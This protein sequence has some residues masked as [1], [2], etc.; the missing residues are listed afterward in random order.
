M[1][2]VTY[3]AS[4]ASGRSGTVGAVWNEWNRRISPPPTD[5]LDDSASI[6]VRLS[7]RINAHRITQA[8][9]PKRRGI[10]NKI[11]IIKTPTCI[12]VVAKPVL[13][14]SQEFHAQHLASAFQAFA[15]L[16]LHDLHLMPATGSSA[17]HL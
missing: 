7:I 2:E 3:K 17:R 15:K 13:S 14:I 6:K 9:T 10:P 4:G 16:L 8:H 5:T 12:M 11:F 1:E